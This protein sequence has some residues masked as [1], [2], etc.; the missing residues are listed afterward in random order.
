MTA[1]DK[2]FPVKGNFWGCLLDSRGQVPFHGTQ[3]T[4][5]ERVIIMVDRDTN[6]VVKKYC[7]KTCQVESYSFL[8]SLANL[9]RKLGFV[10]C[11]HFLPSKPITRALGVRVYDLCSMISILEW[12]TDLAFTVYLIQVI[13]SF[14]SCH[15]KW[16]LIFFFALWPFNY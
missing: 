14:H 6:I 7:Q 8:S 3:Q 9:L 2:Q 12:C 13:S 10:C 4:L 11:F 1:D 15:I 16:F 5:N